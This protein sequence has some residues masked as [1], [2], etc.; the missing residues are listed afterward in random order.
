MKEAS[1]FVNQRISQRR[2]GCKHNI[3]ISAIA[4]CSVFITVGKYWSRNT[5]RLILNFLLNILT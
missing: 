1:V 4:Q 2:I 5:D 3:N